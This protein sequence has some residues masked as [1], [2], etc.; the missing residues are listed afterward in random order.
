MKKILLQTLAMAV[1]FAG[2]A[3]NEIDAPQTIVTDAPQTITASF[4][5]MTKVQLSGLNALWNTHDAISVFAKSDAHNKYVHEAMVDGSGNKGATFK[6][7]RTYSEATKVLSRNYAVFP[8]RENDNAASEGVLTTRIKHNQD[9]DKGKLLMNAPMV[10]VSDDNDFEFINVASILRF[11]VK[12]AEDFTDACVLNSIKLTSK[13]MNLCG[14]VDINT[15]EDIWTAVVKA[16]G[17]HTTMLKGAADTGVNTTLTTEYLPFCLVIPPGTYPA[18]DL[19]ITLTYNETD[20]RIVVYAKELTI[21]ANKV[22]DINCTIK[23][24]VQAGITVTTGGIFEFNGHPHLTCHTASVTGGV[25][26]S[27]E[28]VTVSELGVLFKRSGKETDLVLENLKEKPGTN[29]VKQVVASEIAETAVLKLTDLVGGVDKSNKYAY[30]YYAKLSDG[31]VVYGQTMDFNTD[32]YGF[33]EVKAGTFKMG[34]DEGEN[35]YSA[36]YG[37]SPAHMV[38]LT[39]DFEI[40]KYEVSIPEF[41][42]FLNECS[43]VKYADLLSQYLAATIND[44]NIYYA[45]KNTEVANQE[46]F[47]LTYTDGVWSSTRKKFPIQRVTKYGADQY[48]KWLTETLNDGYTYRLPTEAEWE[49]AARGGQL[50]KGYKYSGSNTLNEVAKAK[51]S[52]KSGYNSISRIGERY[53][54]ELG[55][56]DMSG[57][58]FEFV[59]D[60]SDKNWKNSEGAL[61]SYFMFCK[62]GVQDPTGPTASD[63]Y[64]FDGKYYSIQKGGSTNE[65]TSNAAFCPGFRRNDRENETYHHV[66]GG[67]RVVRVKK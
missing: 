8:C 5:P 25:S 52:D 12:K 39:K 66:C 17:N 45:I 4:D 65:G 41:V 40:G 44:R 67:F 54:N 35:G 62:D 60:R 9:Y 28:G 14:L 6:Y 21:G 51:A 57:N 33:V 47:A 20:A 36:S 13:T 56:Y 32:V 55:I 22:Q 64:S 50:S 23:P 37:T 16:E 10:A 7:D 19:T 15:S 34:A 18:E 1:L 63:G 11:N 30:R 61:I 3:K 49:Y 26:G 2:C 46:D 27:Q 29:D 38:T 48:C 58:M 59:K 24:A 31:S 43:D 42:N 53:P